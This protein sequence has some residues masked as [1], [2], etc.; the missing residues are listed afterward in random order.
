[1]WY[2]KNCSRMAYA[3]RMREIERLK[4]IKAEAGRTK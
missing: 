3:H 2:I 1:M 4:R